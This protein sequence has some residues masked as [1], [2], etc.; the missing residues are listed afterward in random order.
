MNKRM[1]EWDDGRMRE[2]WGGRKLGNVNEK[3]GREWN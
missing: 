2:E 1:E 3:N